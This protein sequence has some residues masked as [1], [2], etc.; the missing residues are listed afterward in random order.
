TSLKK[1]HGGEPDAPPASLGDDEEEDAKQQAQH[2]PPPPPKDFR[3]D[4]QIFMGLETRMM[5]F[6]MIQR[7]M[8]ATQ[9]EILRRFRKGYG[10][11]PLS[12]A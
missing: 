12:S 7:E 10:N 2:I 4:R 9:Y 6:E 8:Q 5:T 1:S 11:G 3:T